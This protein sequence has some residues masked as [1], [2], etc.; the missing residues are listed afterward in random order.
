MIKMCEYAYQ[1]EPVRLRLLDVG[2]IKNVYGNKNHFYFGEY[3][4]VWTQS[5]PA[6]D[7]SN[8]YVVIRNSKED[9]SLASQ[10][11]DSNLMMNRI[12]EMPISEWERYIPDL[13]NK[14]DCG[15]YM[16]EP[17]GR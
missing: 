7:I 17:I 9:L 16:I 10:S 3:F 12:D 4:A 2:V 14:I 11:E 1:Y 8:I 13:Q 6:E 15:A 5:S